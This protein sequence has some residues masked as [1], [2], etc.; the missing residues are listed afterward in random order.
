MVKVRRMPPRSTAV[1]AGVSLVIAGAV[2]GGGPAV[3]A[4]RAA[5]VPGPRAAALAQILR[6]GIGLRPGGA[7]RHVGVSEAAL[8]AGGRKVP[9]P[10]QSSVLNGIFCTSSANCWAVGSYTPSSGGAPRNEVLHWNGRKWSQLAVINPG[11]TGASHLSELFAVR[12]TSARNCWTVGDASRGTADFNQVLHWNGRKWSQVSTPT[13][14]GTLSGDVNEL[15][16]VVCASA[17]SCWADGDYGTQASGRETVLNQVLH[18]NG[19]SWSL[20]KVPNPGGT[21]FDDVQAIDAIRCASVRNCLAVGTYGN[22][23][24]FKLRNE[25]LH[26]NG[27]KW[28]K[29]TTPNPGGTGASGDVSELTALGCSASNCWAAGTYGNVGTETFLNQLLH[30]NGKKWSQATVPNPDGTG[31]AASN[32]LLGA[33]CISATSCWAVGFYGSISGGTGAILNEALRWNGKKWSQAATPNPGGTANEDANE[34]LGV[35]CTSA[36]N[37]WAVGDQTTSGSSELNQALHWN[38][39]KWSTG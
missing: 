21:G 20:V 18:W 9:K 27:K 14:G 13:P 26:W 6:H 29:L 4:G 39:T 33:S 36:G 3:A 15:F 7:G 30:W 25:A 28:S 32:E 10:G 8:P 31:T 11:G 2:A 37:C 24:T 16:D 19:K 17:A 35:R 34:L 23:R 22:I 5:R 12:C 1:L 38:G